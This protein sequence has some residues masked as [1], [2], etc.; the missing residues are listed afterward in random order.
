MMSRAIAL[1][2]FVCNRQNQVEVIFYILI[3]L[4]N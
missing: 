1:V 4:E 2:R 3:I